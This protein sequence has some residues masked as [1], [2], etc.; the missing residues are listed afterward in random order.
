MTENDVVQK[1]LRQHATITEFGP[2]LEPQLWVE[3][4][5]LF[6]VE[7]LDNMF[8]HIN[9]EEVLPTPEHLEI[10][11]Y[12]YAKVNPVAGPIH[13]RGL[14]AG[15]LLVLELVDLIPIEQG[16]TGFMSG[17]GCFSNHPDY[18]EL[19]KPYTCITYHKPGPSGTTSDGTGMFNVTARGGL[20]IMA[21]PGN[22]RH[23][24]TKRHRKHPCQPRPLGGEHRLQ[25]CL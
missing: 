20:S 8:G 24:P 5:E 7:T 2:H 14:K 16:W 4:G 13:V 11:R 3:P 22:H 12:Q 15:D 6:G 23:C 10:L 17:V 9:S 18:P 25:A 21:F 1:I 19:Q